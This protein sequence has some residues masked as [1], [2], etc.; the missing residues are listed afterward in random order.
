MKT[1]EIYDAWK[2][3]KNQMDMDNGF[4]DKVMNRIYQY[5]REKRKPLFD[6]HRLIELI[7]T[8]PLGKAAAIAA[9][10]VIGLLRITFVIYAF[11]GC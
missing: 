7:S 8:R 11:L 1:E 2:E 5:E 3:Q 6:G 9:G 10:A 4:S